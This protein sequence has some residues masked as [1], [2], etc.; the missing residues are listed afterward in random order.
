[1]I[2]SARAE[3]IKGKFDLVFLDVPCSNTGVFRRRPDALW[4]LTPEDFA[5]I[6]GVQQTILAAAAGLTAAGGQL[7]YS[8]CSL[9]AEEN[10]L[11]IRQFIAGCGDFT[12]QEEMQLIPAMDHDGAYAARL[13]KGANHA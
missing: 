9:E 5:D 12:L 7:V 4:R 13:Q 3:E 11:Q 1:M 10:T 2:S 8:T 6:V